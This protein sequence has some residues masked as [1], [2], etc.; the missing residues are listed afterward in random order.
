MTF[1][2]SPILLYCFISFYL[3]MDIEI[4]N[5]IITA[6]IISTFLMHSVSLLIF[7]L[8]EVIFTLETEQQTNL[9]FIRSVVFLIAKTM[10]L[11]ALVHQGVKRKV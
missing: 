7:T 2:S 8:K 5:N 3:M 4:E 11:A 9:F 1:M 10:V 6:F